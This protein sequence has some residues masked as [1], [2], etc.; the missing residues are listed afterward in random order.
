MKIDGDS[1]TEPRR[2]RRALKIVLK[3]RFPF[4]LYLEEANPTRINGENNK[5]ELQ[6]AEKFR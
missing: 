3:N 6:I 5:S 4:V 2:N 1:I